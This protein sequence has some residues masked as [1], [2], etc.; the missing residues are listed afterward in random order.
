MSGSFVLRDALP[1]THTHTSR[2]LFLLFPAGVDSCFR[3]SP[4]G[5]RRSRAAGGCV[6]WSPRRRGYVSRRSQGGPSSLGSDTGCTGGLA[7]LPSTPSGPTA[8]SLL[9]LEP[10]PEHLLHPLSFLKSQAPEGRAHG[11]GTVSIHEAAAERRGCA[12][13]TGGGVAQEEPSFK[14]PRCAGQY[15]SPSHL[16]PFPASFFPALP[17]SINFSLSCPIATLLSSLPLPRP[18][19]SS[20]LSALSN[21]PRTPP[22]SPLCAVIVASA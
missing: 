15:F 14:R 2:T 9:S 12:V 4:P 8:P 18:N 21:P 10:I 1:N 13:A 22:S 19:K 5:S 17:L 16:S 20:Y 3:R 7:G 11:R 6:G